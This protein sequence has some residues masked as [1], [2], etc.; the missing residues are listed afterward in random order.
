[1]PTSWWLP[2]VGLEAVVLAVVEV[3][4]VIELPQELAVITPLLNR[5]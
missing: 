2:G 3:L 4:G 1:M 5:L